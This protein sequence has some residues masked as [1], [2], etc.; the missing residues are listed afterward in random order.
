MESIALDVYVLTALRFPTE[1]TELGASSLEI[2]CVK[3]CDADM[4]QRPV[5][6]WIFIATIWHGHILGLFG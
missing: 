6:I 4:L 3:Q 2:V 1:L 5:E